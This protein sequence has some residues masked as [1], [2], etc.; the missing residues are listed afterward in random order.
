MRSNLREGSAWWKDP[1][2]E[3]WNRPRSSVQLK[4]SVD[5]ALKDIERVIVILIAN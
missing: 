1:V 2:R 5:P 3:S 4:Y